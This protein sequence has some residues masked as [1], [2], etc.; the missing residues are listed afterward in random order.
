[1]I[2]HCAM[3]RWADDAD[4]GAKQAVRDGIDRLPGLIPSIRAYAHGDDLGLAEG[5]WDYVVV[6][7]FDDVDGYLAYARDPEHQTLIHDVVMRAVQARA[8][9]Q[10]EIG[11]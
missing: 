11:S 9:V 10:Y 6:G 1:M 3:F 4:D 5:T 7:D 8:A 2:R